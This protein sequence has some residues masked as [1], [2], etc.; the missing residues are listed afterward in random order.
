MKICPTCSQENKDDAE[1]CEGCGT[2]FEM[3]QSSPKFGDPMPRAH[4]WQLWLGAWCLVA[5]ATLVMHPAH[6]VAVPFFPLGLLDWLPHG[7]QTAIEGWM[8]GAWS[9]G[10]MLYAFLSV[11]MFAAK[12]TGVFFIIYVIFCVLL[13]LN[14]VGCQRVMEAASQI[15]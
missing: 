12:R 3:E 6:I 2:K 9:I 1:Q 8:I 13:L 15:H 7:E 5:I 14:V 11:A 4:K 10:W